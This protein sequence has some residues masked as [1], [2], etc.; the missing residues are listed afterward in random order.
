[1]DWHDWVGNF[2]YFLLAVSYLV[3]NMIWLRSVA[4]LALTLEAVYFY[5][6]ADKP[7]WVGIFWAAVFVVINLVQL[8]IIYRELS[9]VKLSDEDRLLQKGAFS[10]LSEI[11]IQRIVN[12]G[13]WRTVEKGFELTQENSKVT[14]IM[15]LVAGT[16]SVH[17]AG[18][19]VTTLHAGALVG[20]I[21]FVTKKPATATVVVQVESRIFVVNVVKLE[22]LLTKFPEMDKRIHHVVE[23]DL[24]SKLAA[25]V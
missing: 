19:V 1:M 17:V 25:L 22:A 9:K 21:S 5:F 12:I 3:T 13:E 4:V 10:G 11:E 16:A 7:L 14:E 23:L 24:T 2:C 8:A 15:V 18:R 20:E 6:S